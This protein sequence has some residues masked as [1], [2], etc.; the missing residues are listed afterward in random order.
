MK[1][2]KL[3]NVK[4]KCFINFANSKFDIYSVDHLHDTLVL[5]F[6]IDSPPAHR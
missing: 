1:Q 5:M 4:I 3:L 6:D 2:S